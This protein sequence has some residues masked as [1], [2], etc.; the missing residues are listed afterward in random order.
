[1]STNL[2]HTKVP[3]ALIFPTGN[4]SG[5][6]NVLTLFY[7]TESCEKPDVHILDD[8]V[9]KS[10]FLPGDTIAYSCPEGFQTADNMAT[11]TT[12]C[13]I[14][15]EWKPAPRCLGKYISAC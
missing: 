6:Q 8:H 1:M 2:A 4:V 12:S 3:T 9:D 5:L 7:S 15:G 13:E 14:N 10:V 11:G